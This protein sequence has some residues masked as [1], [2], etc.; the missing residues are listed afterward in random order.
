MTTYTKKTS[1]RINRMN[2]IFDT[3]LSLRNFEIQNLGARN[4]FILTVNVALFAYAI[5]T[6]NK[7]SFLLPIF[8]FFVSCLQVHMA[9][10]AKFWQEAWEIKLSQIERELYRVYK[11]ENISNKSDPFIHLF[12]SLEKEKKEFQP[13]KSHEKEMRNLVIDKIGDNFI[14]PY[15]IT[16]K[17]SVSRTPIYLGLCILCF[18]VILITK[19]LCIKGLFFC[20]SNGI[21]C[22]FLKS[23]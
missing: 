6:N 20:S 11:R 16:R 22:N 17:F 13:H 10:G 3:V 8:G 18:W 21:F 1:Y 5:N 14:V 15:L 9:A 23:I 12:T 2:S 19:S 4:S 7:E